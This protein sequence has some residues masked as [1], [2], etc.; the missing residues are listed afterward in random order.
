MKERNNLVSTSCMGPEFNPLMIFGIVQNC[1]Y[2]SSSRRLARWKPVLRTA[3]R[4]RVGNAETGASRPSRCAIPSPFRHC[5]AHGVRRFG[6]HPGHDHLL[7][8]PG[9]QGF[10]GDSRRP[11]SKERAN[12]TPKPGIPSARCFP[13]CPER[14][15]GT[16]H[17]FPYIPAMPSCLHARMHA[18]RQTRPAAPFSIMNG[19]FPNTDA[20]GTCGRL[21]EPP[22]SPASATGSAAGLPRGRPL[23]YPRLRACPATDS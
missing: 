10:P 13:C 18:K 17:A 22:P 20:A 19:S 23:R 14:H 4:P 8:A 6:I 12:V 9:I 21:L 5:P 2:K 1:I 3:P 7:E 16:V 15:A 11:H